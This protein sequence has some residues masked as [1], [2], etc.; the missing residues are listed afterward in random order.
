MKKQKQLWA[1]AIA[2]AALITAC[3]K[4]DAP[5]TIIVQPATGLYILNEGNYNSNNTTL[6]YY[7]LNAGKAYTDFYAQNNGNVGLGSGGDDILIYG[8]KLYIVMNGSNNVTVIDKHT[9]KLITRIKNANSSNWAPEQI[10]SYSSNVLVTGNDGTVAKID[11][12]SLSIQKITTVGSNPMGLVVAGNNLYVANSG[13]YNYPVYDSTV[14]VVNLNSM[15][16]TMKIKVGT[17]PV[18]VTADNAGNVYVSSI[19][20]YGNIPG[21][22]VRINTSTN[23]VT[24]SADTSVGKICFYNN[25]LYGIG[26]YGDSRIR[27]FNTK[28]F[29]ATNFITDG[30]VI[31]IPY[32]VNVDESN[33]DVY[34]TDAI[35]YKSPGIVYCFDKTGKK[36]FSFSVAPGISP[37]KVVFLR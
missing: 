20:N 30:T 32:G 1:L 17:N 22:I 24:K 6:T 18:N 21:N 26:G 11:T 13:G 7:D 5:S 9:G 12:T 4:N 8:S 33:G 25:Q 14:S 29:T 27:I 31:N 3:S 28:D 19:G 23:T 15:I 2:I 10:T 35:D 16:E 36:K 37:D 34:I